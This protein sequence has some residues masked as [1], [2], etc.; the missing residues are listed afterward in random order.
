MKRFVL[1]IVLACLA[2]PALAKADSASD[3]DQHVVGAWTLQLTD[4]EG[5]QRTPMVIVGRQYDKYVAWYIGKDEPEA[6]QDVQLKGE[7]LVG[8]LTPK[9]RPEVKV[10]LEAT[11][12]GDGQTR[13]T[14][15]YRDDQGHSGSF[16]FTG[17]RLP[18]S[19]FDEVSTWKL[20]FNTPDYEKHEP[21]ITVV[22]K[23]GKM[24]AWYGSRDHQL[25][26]RSLS[27]QNDT[28]VASLTAAT[29]DGEQID[30][31]FRGTVTDDAV[32]GKIEY[33]FRG[34]SGSLPFEG[35]RE[36]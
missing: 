36:S 16:G 18:M 33:R 25:P 1:G 26:V 7:T 17:Q 23:D 21:T 35:K 8:S 32:K 6:F 30:V 19:A 20:T 15:K 27:V 12:T 9:E 5:V 28:V 2:M 31:T 22:S 4:P 34:N 3:L 13:G 11:W 14:A 29:R 24:Y 10:T